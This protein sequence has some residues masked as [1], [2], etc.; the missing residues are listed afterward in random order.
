M[1]ECEFGGAASGDKQKSAEFQYFRSEPKLNRAPN[2]S[3]MTDGG[4]RTPIFIASLD[5]WGS[6]E[7]ASKDRECS[8]RCVNTSSGTGTADPASKFVSGDKLFDIAAASRVSTYAETA[9]EGQ[10][11][12]EAIGHR[13]SASR[14]SML[15]K[16][17]N[18]GS[19]STKSRLHLLNSFVTS[20][21]SQGS[22][23]GIS[24]S[25]SRGR[26]G[27]AHRSQALMWISSLFSQSHDSR[28]MLLRC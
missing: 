17:A 10:N 21:G 26:T 3:V 16:F 22:F 12:T 13:V 6:N 7:G 20:I 15:A 24:T 14:T 11:D 9:L 4:G 19:S 25:R 1:T 18:A 5:E 8:L 2:I 28:P 27:F 23:G